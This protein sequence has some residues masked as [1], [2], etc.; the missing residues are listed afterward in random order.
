MFHVEHLRDY[1][2]RKLPV[3][4]VERFVRRAFPN[5]WDGSMWNTSRDYQLNFV[6]RIAAYSSNSVW[7]QRNVF[8]G[9]LH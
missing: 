7:Q 2:D 9:S 6:E 8:L 3:F 4:H 1:M 5:L